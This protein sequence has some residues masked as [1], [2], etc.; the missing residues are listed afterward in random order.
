MH[1]VMA[2]ARKVP[3]NDA[4]RFALARNRLQILRKLE[5]TLDMPMAIL[6]AVWLYLLVIELVWGLSRFGERI[7]TVIWIVFIVD[8]MLRLAL[9]P[10]KFR[11]IRHNWLTAVSLLL[12]ALRF[13]RIGRRGD[14]VDL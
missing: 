9:A 7:T 3:E 6:G 5:A 4:V 14:S 10:R 12:P 8:F 11:F 13:L 2:T 1:R